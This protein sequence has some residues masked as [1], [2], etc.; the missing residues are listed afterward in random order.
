M[1]A[2]LPALGI[3]LGVAAIVAVDLGSGST[4][5][6]FRRTLQR[7]PQVSLLTIV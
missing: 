5:S 6:S 4:V 2:L 3:A 7:P 1:Q